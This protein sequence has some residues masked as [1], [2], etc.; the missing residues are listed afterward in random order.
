M[1]HKYLNEETRSMHLDEW[2]DVNAGIDRNGHNVPVV[3]LE[4]IYH[5]VSRGKIFLSRGSLLQVPEVWMLETWATIGYF[6]IEEIKEKSSAGVDNNSSELESPRE[7]ARAGGRLTTGRASPMPQNDGLELS[8]KSESSTEIVWISLHPTML[9]VGCGPETAPY[10]FI[11]MKNV[12]L[13]KVQ[14]VYRQVVLANASNRLEF[15]LLLS[16]GQFQLLEV[17]ELDVRIGQDADFE[18][19]VVTLSKYSDND[20]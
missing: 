3:L 12:I 2:V 7:I 14:F 5:S 15:C 1:L 4:N 17:P 10:G 9:F 20:P 19:W 13:K 16:D 11:I 18:H 8:T 6:N